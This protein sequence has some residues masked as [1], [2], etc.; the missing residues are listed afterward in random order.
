MSS[1]RG[2]SSYVDYYIAEVGAYKLYNI[3]NKYIR[4]EISNRVFQQVYLSHVDTQNSSAFYQLG[5]TAFSIYGLYLT[6]YNDDLCNFITDEIR[7]KDYDSEEAFLDDF[8]DAMDNIKLVDSVLDNYSM[9]LSIDGFLSKDCSLD[10]FRKI[11]KAFK[12]DAYCI[13]GDECSKTTFIKYCIENGLIKD[14][15]DI[16]DL[17]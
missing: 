3:V 8:N 17:L 9:K 2:Y 6:Q 7:N 13:D 10:E 15:S 16:S 14:V 12:Y 5:E 4:L 1:Y 11:I